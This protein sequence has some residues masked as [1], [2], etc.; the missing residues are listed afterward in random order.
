MKKR[1]RNERNDEDDL[2]DVSTE[3]FMINQDLKEGIESCV[4][5]DLTIDK[6]FKL[7]KMIGSPSINGEAWQTCIINALDPKSSCDLQKGVFATKKIP[8]DKQTLDTSTTFLKS[9]ILKNEVWTEIV[10]MMLCRQLVQ[11]N[12][13]PNL[14]M[15]YTYYKCDSCQ[16][17]NPELVEKNLPQCLLMVNELAAHGDIK[18]WMAR[19]N[20]DQETWLSAIFQ[21]FAGL[22]SLQKYFGLTHHDLHWGN[23]LVHEDKR[24]GYWHYIIDD[25]DYFVPNKGYRFTLWDFGWAFIRNKIEIEWQVQD[26]V[27]ERVENGSLWIHDYSHISN[28][29]NWY[30][31]AYED[32][33]SEEYTKFRKLGKRKFPTEIVELLDSF[34]KPRDFFT[35]Q[36]IQKYMNKA[37]MKTIQDTAIRNANNSAPTL[38]TLLPLV[39]ASEFG[40]NVSNNTIV[41]VYN[42]DAE[43]NLPKE[44]SKFK[45]KSHIADFANPSS[46]AF[47]DNMISY[48]VVLNKQNGKIEKKAEIAFALDPDSEKPIVPVLPFRRRLDRIVKQKV[49]Y[50]KI[51]IN[52]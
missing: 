15:Y 33:G 14:P 13:C 18:N 41:D 8:M 23:V 29:I 39:F 30:L 7:V 24:P 36:S 22:Y 38:R 1:Q 12:I 47:R 21:I 10:G 26:Y 43:V 44:L 45:H 48:S 28:M 3:K 51:K 5:N 52:E 19:A 50:K 32:P 20:Y 17:G 46:D 31:N 6:K 9:K 40:Q 35:K 25:Q 49:D 42:M 37:K 4:N 16:Y 11:Q 34:S 2:Q 27:E